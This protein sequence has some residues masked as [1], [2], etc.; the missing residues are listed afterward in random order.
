MV[1]VVEVVPILVHFPIY[2]VL[3]RDL[4]YLQVIQFKDAETIIQYFLFQGIDVEIVHLQYKEQHVQE[5]AP[6]QIQQAQVQQIVIVPI[7]LGQI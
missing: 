3:D 7:L 2:P 6:I 1:I 5:V 4:I